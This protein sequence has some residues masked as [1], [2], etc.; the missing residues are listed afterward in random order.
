MRTKSET[1]NFDRSTDKYIGTEAV[2]RTY[3]GEAT[4]G[5]IE[6]F[7]G[8]RAIL[9]FANGGWAYSGHTLELVK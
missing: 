4:V 7:D 6:R 8:T 1:P 2:Y 9:R 3:D 5:T